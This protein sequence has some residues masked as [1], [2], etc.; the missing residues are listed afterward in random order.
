MSNPNQVIW[1]TENSHFKI[2]KAKFSLLRFWNARDFAFSTFQPKD[3]TV[4]TSVPW[5]VIGLLL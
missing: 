2:F 3:E 1:S 4:A 5:G